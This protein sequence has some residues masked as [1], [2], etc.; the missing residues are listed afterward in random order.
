MKL[1]WNRATVTASFRPPRYQLFTITVMS[2]VARLSDALQATVPTVRSS[3][4]T[5]AGTRL[6]HPAIAVLLSRNVTVE[7]RMSPRLFAGEYVALSSMSWIV[8]LS[9]TVAE[10]AFVGAQANVVPV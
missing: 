8:A 6:L 1:G 7:R 2:C 4:L 3:A 9:S 10:L 5:R